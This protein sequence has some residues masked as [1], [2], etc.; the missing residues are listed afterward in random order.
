MYQR[1]RGE[2]LISHERSGCL[3]AILGWLGL[4]PKAEEEP[5]EQEFPYHVRD[6]FLSPAEVSFYHVLR[7]IVG[8]K[9]AVCPKVSLGD[10]F[11][12]ATGDYGT[13]RSWMN[14]IDRKHVDFVI[15]DAGT[16][17]PQLGVELD[18]ASHDSASR[19][20]RDAFVNRVFE[21]A[22]LPLA[23]VSA[24]LQYNTDEVRAKLG[25]ALREGTEGSSEEPPRTA[26]PVGA[27]GGTPPQCPKCEAVMVVRTVKRDGPRQG[28]RFWGC[29]N[30]PKCRGTRELGEEGGVS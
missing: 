14:R 2:A 21:A 4:A 23:R 6:D 22:G 11:Y 16:L 26:E 13:N 28:E 9:A 20:E 24:Q 12:A 17:D 25:R 5:E 19:R 18:D 15:C 3:T 8:D 30:F 27:A 29:P 1:N 7:G 10:L